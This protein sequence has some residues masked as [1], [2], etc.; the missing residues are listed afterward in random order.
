MISNTA[1]KKYALAFP[2]TEEAPHF[3]NK[4]YKVKKKI[5]VTHNEK[6]SRC[7]VKLTPEEQS[8]FCLMDK[9]LIY[10]VPNKWGKQGWTLV[11]LHKINKEILNDVLTAAYCTVAPPK[12]AA[13]FIQ[14]GQEESF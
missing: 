1:F 5:F 7:C 3:E 10:P 2:E 8:L 4:A 14:K 13:P 11:N 6:E 12:L 9:E